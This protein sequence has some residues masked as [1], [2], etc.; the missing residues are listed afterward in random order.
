MAPGYATGRTCI[1]KE[2]ATWL[3]RQLYG[4]GGADN[5]GGKKERKRRGGNRERKR[6][7]KE[8]KKEKKKINHLHHASTVQRFNVFSHEIC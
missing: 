5:K 4:A 3:R 7:E 6:T 2:F 8:R 1:V